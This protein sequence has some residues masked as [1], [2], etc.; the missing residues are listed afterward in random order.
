M[1]FSL[2]N[3]SVALFAC[4][5]AL[6]FWEE[7]KIKALE[8]KRLQYIRNFAN[9]FLSKLKVKG[10]SINEDLE[11]LLFNIYEKEQEL[12]M[13]IEALTPHRKIIKVLAFSLIAS[14]VYGLFSKILSSYNISLIQMSWA[15]IRLSDIF[16]TISIMCFSFS[17]LWGY[18]EFKYIQKITGK[19]K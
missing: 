8:D 13:P 5:L 7:P 15:V 9:D 1:D 19:F 17:I 4:E 2:I 14:V 12:I 16:A 18:Q 6:Y 10:G 11:M 3:I